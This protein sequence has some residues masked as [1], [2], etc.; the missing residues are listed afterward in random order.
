MTKVV[1][2]PGS[3]LHENCNPRIWQPF[4]LRRGDRIC[5]HLR[6]RILILVT[7]A[8]VVRARTNTLLQIGRKTMLVKLSSCKSKNNNVT[9]GHK[10]ISNRGIGLLLEQF[11]FW[12]NKM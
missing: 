7:F 9:A 3:N 11:A 10:I 5:G 12:A 6:N 2:L 4:D 8:C 1:E